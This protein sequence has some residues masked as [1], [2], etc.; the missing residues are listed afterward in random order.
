MILTGRKVHSC[1]FGSYFST[2]SMGDC[3]LPNPPITRRTSLAPEGI[4]K[5]DHAKQFTFSVFL[6]KKYV[7][8]I[9][10]SLKTT[11]CTRFNFLKVGARRQIF[12]CKQP[13]VT[14]QSAPSKKVSLQ[15]CL[16]ACISWYAFKIDA[17]KRV[18]QVKHNHDW[19]NL[20]C[21]RGPCISLRSSGLKWNFLA[22]STRSRQGR[23]HLMRGLKYDEKC[24]SSSDSSHR[25][26]CVTGVTSASM[27]SVM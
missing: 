16:F 22:S 15:W 4:D 18:G 27:T 19:P 17:S 7:Y 9:V 21:V 26:R 1:V 13:F 8:C 25:L 5:S 2:T 14:S 3:W 24:I 11:V 6:P 23:L 10:L 12:F 20:A